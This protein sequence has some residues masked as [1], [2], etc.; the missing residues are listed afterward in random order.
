MLYLPDCRSTLKA[1]LVCLCII[2]GIRQHAQ[3]VNMKIT[4]H[5]LNIPVE[6]SAKV[7]PVRLILTVK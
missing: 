5:Y 4:K 1:L 3:P 6:K 7:K 2:P